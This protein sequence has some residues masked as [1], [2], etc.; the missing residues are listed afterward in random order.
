M[1]ISGFG[2]TLVRLREE[3]I[4]MLR[5]WRNDRRISRHMDFREHISEQAQQQWFASLDQERDFFFLIRSEGEFHGLIHFSAIDWRTGIGQSGLFIRTE[6]YQ[7]THLP[8]SASALMLEYFLTRT[9]L[10]AIEAKV[11]NDN[12]VALSYNLS[13]G[14]REVRSEQPERFYRLRLEK[15]NFYRVFGRQLDLLK[16]VHGG[17][18]SVQD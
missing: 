12:A 6:D 10:K 1:T 18:I 16:R 14:F 3:H 9:P 7:G 4:E 15:E 8:V 13:L 2:I 11:M 5:E 17:S